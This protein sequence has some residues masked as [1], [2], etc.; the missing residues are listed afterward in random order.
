MNQNISIRKWLTQNNY[1]DVTVL[2]DSVMEGWKLKGT[3]IRR[4]WWDVLAGDKN[5][6]ASTIEGITFPVLRAA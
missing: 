5:G 6:K 3:K 2:I 4:N 1:Q